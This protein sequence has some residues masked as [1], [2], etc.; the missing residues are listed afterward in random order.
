MISF[1]IFDSYSKITVFARKRIHFD[2]KLQFL[3]KN[4]SKEN[5]IFNFQH[6]STM[7]MLLN[8]MLFQNFENFGHFRSFE[9]F[10]QE[11]NFENSS[12]ITPRII[13]P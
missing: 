13:I 2:F 7:F 10:L 1:S 4:T 3:T 5:G 8:N 12:K 9:I 11:W 6:D